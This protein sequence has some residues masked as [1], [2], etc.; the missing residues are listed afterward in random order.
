M[1]NTF[2]IQK[3]RTD[4]ETAAQLQIDSYWKTYALQIPTLKSTSTT[5]TSNYNAAKGQCE[6]AQKEYD[7]ALKDWNDNYQFEVLDKRT[8]LSENLLTMFQQ[9]DKSKTSF[10]IQ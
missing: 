8:Q 9:T 4:G 5:K 3:A 2:L 6:T 1:I 7:V 10:D